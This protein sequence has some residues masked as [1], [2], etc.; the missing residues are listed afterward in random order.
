MRKHRRLIFGKFGK[1]DVTSS[2]LFP[3]IPY[4]HVY[5]KGGQSGIIYNKFTQI[6][7]TFIDPPTL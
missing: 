2:P 7:F 3:K 6:F 1:V 5:D 4:A